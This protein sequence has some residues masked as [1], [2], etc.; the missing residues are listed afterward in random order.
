[1]IEKNQRGKKKKHKK[2]KKKQKKNTNV[3]LRSRDRCCI[4]SINWFTYAI[5]N[6]STI[7]TNSLVIVYTRWWTEQSSE[8]R[9][10]FVARHSLFLLTTIPA[11]IE[12]VVS[13]YEKKKARRR[14]WLL[15][16]LLL[17]VLRFFHHYRWIISSR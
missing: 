8:T 3:V 17:K 5:R 1:M 9:L 4:Y 2:L 15:E 14:L 13:F 11:G 12:R 6:V 7:M 10:G 16:S